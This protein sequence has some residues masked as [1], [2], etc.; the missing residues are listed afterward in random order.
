M[1]H[2]VKLILDGEYWVHW[3]QDAFFT[4]LPGYIHW[5][6]HNKMVFALFPWS[7]E[8]AFHILFL[9]LTVIWIDCFNSVA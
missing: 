7:C 4:G 1:F 2:V 3:L 8:Y 5:V 6:L 9:F